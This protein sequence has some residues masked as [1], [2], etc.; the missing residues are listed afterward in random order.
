GMIGMMLI[1]PAAWI[2]IYYIACQFCIRA[3]N[4]SVADLLCASCGYSLEVL[5]PDAVCPE[6]GHARET[7][8]TQSA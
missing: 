2:A 7:K 8:L 5:Q 3:I 6:C 1:A 4:R